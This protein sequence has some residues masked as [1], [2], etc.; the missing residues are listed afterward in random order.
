MLFTV[1][2]KL[3]MVYDT[4]KEPEN[5]VIA[6]FKRCIENTNIEIGAINKLFGCEEF[7]RVYNDIE[8]K[9]TMFIESEY[10]D[11]LEFV[12][13][14]F[15][16]KGL[17]PEFCQGIINALDK[18]KIENNL[19]EVEDIMANKIEMTKKDGKLEITTKTKKGGKRM[20]KK[21]SKKNKGKLIVNIKE[22]VK[23]ETKEKEVPVVEATVVEPV[24][25]EEI[26]K[27]DFLAELK[28]ALKEVDFV[29]VVEEVSREDSENIKTVLDAVDLNEAIETAITE[30][31]LQ[32][33]FE[34]IKKDLKDGNVTN[35]EG[36]KELV[37]AQLT[38]IITG[39]TEAVKEDIVEETE[40]NN[41]EAKVE[42]N[43]DK[44]LK[45]EIEE[46]SK[47]IKDGQTRK[48]FIS[49]SITNESI[50]MDEYNLMKDTDVLS[51]RYVGLLMEVGEIKDING[52]VIETIESYLNIA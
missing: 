5:N 52:N 9:H 20:S 41:D 16:E 40:A 27:E 34:E 13:M 35:K 10:A 31:I 46:L 24:K 28:S 15:L 1:N 12:G 29:K 2:K 50:D 19:M 18:I 22:D 26:T 45:Y 3:K 30:E 4:E 47:E 8:T 44:S 11:T 14:N 25:E 38:E 37:K 17:K 7:I 48:Y 32:G 51:Y 49:K 23:K 42:E 39:T 36:L 6:L 21:K 33:D 43:K